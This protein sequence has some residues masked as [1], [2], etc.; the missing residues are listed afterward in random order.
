M[1]I[2]LIILERR[3]NADR[4]D[5]GN[6]AFAMCRA[7]RANK[8]IRSSRFYWYGAD[9]VV[10]LTEGENEALDAPFD[11]EN[12]R[13]A[14]DLTDLARMTMNWRLIEPRTGVETYKSAGR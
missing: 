6:A 12:A 9:T 2:Q 10:I 1:P 5:L 3:D 7:M 14:F 8:G 11:A 4:E 13:A